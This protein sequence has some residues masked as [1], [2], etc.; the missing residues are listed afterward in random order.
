MSFETEVRFKPP[1]VVFK[2]GKAVVVA[3]AEVVL[4]FFGKCNK[5]D[6]VE[7]AVGDDTVVVFMVVPLMTLEELKKCPE[8]K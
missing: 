6:F 8:N 1:L 5:L 3:P 2:G 4:D 7:F